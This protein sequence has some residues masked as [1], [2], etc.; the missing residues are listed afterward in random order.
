MP[1][2][3]C[4]ALTFTRRA[5]AEMRERLT[6]LLPAQAG[7]LMITTFHGLGLTILRE[8]AGRAGLDPGFTVADEKTRL[9]VATEEAGSL[10]AGRRLLSEVARDPGAAGEFARLLASRGLV[11]FDGLIALPLAMLR[12]D[13][14]L[15]ATLAARWRSI[16]VD[17]Y[18]DTDAA[19]YALL[20][21]LAGDGSG[22]AVIGDPDQAIYGF[23]GADV[24]FFLR[25]GRD[26]PGARTVTLTRN[27]RSS[28]VIVS[29]AMQAVAPATLVPGRRMSAVAGPAPGAAERITVH[30]AASDRGEGAWIAQAIDKLLGGASF[31]SLDTGRADGHAGGKLA[32]ADMAVLYRTDAQAVALGQALT[33]AGLPFQKRSMTCWGAGR[34]FRRSCGR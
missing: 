7:R 26:Y 15:A 12:Q 22:L 11:D 9:G 17:E 5:A 10:A 2:E 29:G 27:Y 23:R 21:L 8:H 19:Q 13:P 16:S 32:L 6:A 34:P 31:H 20:R 18:Q 14:A 25:F 3:A 28:P 24:G 1:P 30:E 33:R 4:L